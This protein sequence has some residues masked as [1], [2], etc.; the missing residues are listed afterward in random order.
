MKRRLTDEQEHEIIKLHQEKTT[1]YIAKIYDVSR[2]TISNTLK[3]HNIQPKKPGTPKGQKRGKRVTCLSVKNEFAPYAIKFLSNILNIEETDGKFFL[4]IFCLVDNNRWVATRDQM[5]RRIARNSWCKVCNRNAKRFAA[6]KALE[7]I[8]SSH[9]GKLISEQYLDSNQLLVWECS[10]KKHK[11]WEATAS[12]ITQ[13]SWCKQ[14]QHEQVRRRS[15]I[16]IEDLKEKAASLG[17][18]LVDTEYCGWDFKYLWKCKL[19]HKFRCSAGKVLDGRW[20]S[21]CSPHFLSEEICRAHFEQIFNKK[22]K[23]CKPPWLLSEKNTR[24]EL[25][26]YCDE[27]K[28]AFE[29]NGAQHYRVSRYC[30]SKEELSIIIRNDNRKNTLCKQQGVKLITIP[31][32][33]RKV[34]VKDLKNFIIDECN[35]LDIQL[36]QTTNQLIIDYKNVHTPTSIR[37]FD[38]LIA[39]VRD[40]KGRLLSEKYLGCDTALLWYCDIH[41]K[42]WNAYPKNIKK[43]SWCPVCKGLVKDTS[44][45][46][47]LASKNKG[48]CLSLDEDFVYRHA[49]IVLVWQCDNNHP[50]FTASPRKVVNGYWCTSCKSK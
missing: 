18:S 5:K 46:K 50:S 36:P 41:K 16:K 47:S 3:K 27:L 45:V 49:R 32:L 29:H 21:K 33:N 22:F 10:N 20:C 15:S 48:V 4:D 14:C 30:K 19:G 13:G 2:Q 12:S 34:K 9:G 26:G 35:K 8:A 39:I 31:E 6:Y 23:K 11:T 28:I 24:L 7:D 37:I 40:R 1:G 43:G 42:T 44:W 17:G 38:E 25:D